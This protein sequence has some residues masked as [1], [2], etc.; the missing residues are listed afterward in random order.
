MSVRQY[1]SL[2][3]SKANFENSQLTKAQAQKAHIDRTASVDE[4][5]DTL[6]RI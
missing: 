6:T 4:Q 3:L 5:N 2:F 1:L